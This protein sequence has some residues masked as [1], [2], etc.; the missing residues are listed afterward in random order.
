MNRIVKLASVL[1]VAL[2]AACSPHEQNPSTADPILRGEHLLR[3][4]VNRTETESRVSAGF[5]LV[6]GDVGAT[7]STSVSVKFAW[8]MNDGIYA[9]S[10]LPLEKI[11][12]QVDE[13]ADVPTMKFRWQRCYTKELQ[14][15]MNRCVLYALVTAREKD[16]PVQISLPLNQ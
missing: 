6:V 7:T 10:S 16:W 14:E 9:I 2:L 5:F 11:R 4:M 15:L 12:I 1:F 13:K 3:K 8:K